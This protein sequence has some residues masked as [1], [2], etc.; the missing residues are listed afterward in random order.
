MSV[1]LL[2]VSQCKKS[3]VY[4]AVPQRHSFMC[5]HLYG[6]ATAGLPCYNFAWRGTA[7]QMQSH[8]MWSARNYVY[9]SM[10]M[11]QVWTASQTDLSCLPFTFKN[12]PDMTMQPCHSSSPA[13]RSSKGRMQRGCVHRLKT[14]L[15]T[16]AHDLYDCHSSILSNQAY[17][18]MS[19]MHLSRLWCTNVTISPKAVPQWPKAFV[20]RQ[21]WQHQ[22]HIR[23]V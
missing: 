3:A 23:H 10:Y 13:R 12:M 4:L 21:L 17:L 19:T 7:V 22:Q 14:G 16:R 11:Y 2:F 18:S 9:I 6:V 20:R 8:F 15:A 5:K 1:S